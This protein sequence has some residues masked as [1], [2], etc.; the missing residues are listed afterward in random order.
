M[1][2][3]FPRRNR[4]DKMV[5]AELKIRDA[6]C[7][8]EDMP[9][10]VRLTNAQ[11]LLGRAQDLVADYVDG[12]HHCVACGLVLQS[13]GAIHDCLAAKLAEEQPVL[14]VL[15]RHA[16]IMPDGTLG[17]VDIGEFAGDRSKDLHL[18]VAQARTLAEQLDRML[19]E[20]G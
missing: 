10:D 19:K 15:Y 4:L 20:R 7:G 9:A 12:L 5:P 14:S 13:E 6:I 2:N 18:T 17:C 11:I 16:A 3:D 8:V 1:S